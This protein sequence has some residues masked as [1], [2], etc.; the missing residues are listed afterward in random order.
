[1]RAYQRRSMDCCSACRAVSREELTFGSGLGGGFGLS[2]MVATFVEGCGVS[3]S[4]TEPKE[5]SCPTSPHSPTQTNVKAH[6]LARDSQ[7]P[8]KPWRTSGAVREA[9]VS[10]RR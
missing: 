7:D 1:M 9:Q 4:T 8:D 3:T 10:A 2:F 6:H 5:K